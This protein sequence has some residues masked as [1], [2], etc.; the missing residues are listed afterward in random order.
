M[1]FEKRKPPT[2]TRLP[3]FL[4]LPLEEYPSTLQFFPPKIYISILLNNT[5]DGDLNLGPSILKQRKRCHMCNVRE[6]NTQ[7]PT[8]FRSIVQVI[9]CEWTALRAPAS[10]Y[11][12]CSIRASILTAAPP[13]S[14]CSSP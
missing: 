12:S 11:D 9:S 1:Q 13:L 7:E 2:A 6:V 3:P 8:D 4:I 5:Y 14:A 10:G